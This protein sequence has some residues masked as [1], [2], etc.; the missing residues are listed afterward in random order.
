MEPEHSG[1][2]SQRSL[3]IAPGWPLLLASASLLTMRDAEIFNDRAG[4]API[5]QSPSGLSLACRP[6]TLRSRS[7]T[8][9]V[10]SRSAIDLEMADWMVFRSDAALLAAMTIPI[11][12]GTWVWLASG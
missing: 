3:G 8:P 10:C 11:P 5:R 6:E 4:S 9:I 1:S 2:L 7:R 12:S